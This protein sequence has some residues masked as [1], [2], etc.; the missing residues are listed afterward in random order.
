MI[1]VYLTEEEWL[2]CNKQK[3]LHGSHRGGSSGSGSS[4]GRDK[5]HG[6]KK[7]CSASDS[8]GD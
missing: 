5:S 1:A 8:N 4:G 3:E 2:E 7:S 6:G